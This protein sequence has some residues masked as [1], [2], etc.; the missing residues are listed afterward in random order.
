MRGGSDRQHRFELPLHI[1][2]QVF[3]KLRPDNTVDTRRCESIEDNDRV[4][5]KLMTDQACY[6]RLKVVCKKF[7]QVFQEHPELSDDPLVTATTTKHLVPSILLWLQPV[8][9]GGWP[10]GADS[11]R[12]GPRPDPPSADWR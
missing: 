9:R 11:Y 2:S 6:H 5:N 1:W 10:I 12:P 4:V 8:S 7:Q 3:A